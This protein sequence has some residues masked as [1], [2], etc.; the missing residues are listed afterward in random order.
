M[1][2]KGRKTF[3]CDEAYMVYCWSLKLDDWSDE[4]WQEYLEWRTRLPSYDTGDD[5]AH[6]VMVGTEQKPFDNE[7]IDNEE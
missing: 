6:L 3:E 2:M 1:Y 5:V 4:E 7:E